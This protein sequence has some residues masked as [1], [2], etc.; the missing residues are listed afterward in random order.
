MSC[1]HPK[2]DKIDLIN[3]TELCPQCMVI[4]IK[5]LITIIENQRHQIDKLEGDNPK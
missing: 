3:K 5:T 1:P 4:R 2:Q